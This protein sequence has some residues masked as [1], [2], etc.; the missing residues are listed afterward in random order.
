MQLFSWLRLGGGP[1]L[2]IVQ[3]ERIA[4]RRQ[5]LR[6]AVLGGT[7]ALAAACTPAAAPAAPTA[8]P[9]AAPT[10]A[11]AKPAAAAPTT[12]PAAAPTTAAAAA[13]TTAPA[14]AAQPTT[15]PAAAA[16]QAQPAPVPRNKQLILM[17]AGQQ[18]K[19]ID[20]ELWNPFAPDANHQNGPGILYEPLFFYSAFA[21]KEIPWLAESY[22]YNADYTQLTIKTRSGIM[23]SDG[24]PFSAKDVAFTITESARQG[25][26]IKF[27]SDVATFLQDATAKDD[28]TVVVN[29]KVPAPKFM[30]MMMYKYD[31][32]LYMVPQHVFST[33]TDWS[34]FTA[35]DLSKD[36]PVTTGP[37]KVVF[38]SPDQKIIDQRADWWALKAGLVKAMPA[39]QRIV[40][41]PFPGET[42]TAQAHI[43]NTI[44]CSLD[45]RPNTIKQ[46]LAQ[47]PKIVSWTGNNPPYGYND[48][49][50][51]SLYVDTTKAPW[52]DKDL[53]WAL[54]YSLD[55]Q[56]LIDVAFNGASTLTQLPM[57]SAEAYPGLKPFWD[58]AKPLLDKYPT[59][60]YN[61]DKAAALLQGKGYT[62]AAMAS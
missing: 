9:A 15:A 58:A 55:R 35:F 60:E 37:W 8:A 57:P 21:N 11:P 46:I 25:A 33:S 45:L 48:W 51:T 18:G 10:T 44:D 61:L 39:V 32:G 20:A 54:S 26:K 16:A 49:W 7:A 2:D 40:Y 23:W 12:A 56:Q 59:N 1:T 43:T 62:K 6:L 27:G 30:F 13:P 14:A 22:A 3:P 17:W 41:L 53:R 31:L 50:P 5:F 36:W 52:S 24:Q 38:S 47:N 19:Y 42:Q 34:T 4:S 28:T 29:F